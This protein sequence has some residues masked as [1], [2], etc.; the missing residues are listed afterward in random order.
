MRKLFAPNLITRLGI[1]V[2]LASVLPLLLVGVITY[3]VSRSVIEREV[4]SYSQALVNQQAD[5]LDLILHQ[6]AALLANVSGVDAIRDALQTEYD[7][8][9]YFT[10]LST[11]TQIGNILN[12]FINLQG[13]GLVSIDIFGVNGAHYHVGDTLDISNI[14]TE[15]LADLWR[16]SAAAENSVL[17]AGVEQN[18]NSSST[19]TPVITVVRQLRTTDA[20]TLSEEPLALVVV[21]Y[22][23]DALHGYFSQVNLGEGAYMIVLDS[24]NRLVYHPNRTL[25]GMTISAA[26]AEHL[27]RRPAD[28]LVVDG[29]P[30]LITHV[31]S[32]V[33]GWRL[34]SFIPTATLAAH[35]NTIG[36]MTFFAVLAALGL[37]SIVTWQ[38]SSTVV[39]PLKKITDAFRHANAGKLDE[40]IDISADR[41]DEIGD[42]VHSFNVF[43]VNLRVR[44]A[45]VQELHR[46]KEAA[47]AANTA[48]SEFLANISHEIRTPMNGIIGMT[49]LLLTTPINDEQRDYLNTLSISA[50]S[51][52]TLINDI[53]DVAK[54]EAGKLALTMA[55]FNLRQLI[56]DVLGLLAPRAFGKGIELL[57]WVEMETPESCVGDLA[58]L[59]QVLLNLLGNAI[60]FTEHG[61]VSLSVRPHGA[62]SDPFTL[63]FAVQDTGIG[64]PAD[65]QAS[66]FEPFTQADGSTTRR[67]GGTGL[68]LTISRNLVELMGGELWVESRDSEGST[69][70]F[71]VKLAAPDPEEASLPVHKHWPQL[72]GLTAL[73]Y[74]EQPLLRENLQRIVAT[75]GLKA[76]T[77]ASLDEARAHLTA[78]Q[79]GRAV[80]FMLFDVPVGE[81]AVLE[82]TPAALRGLLPPPCVSVPLLSPNDYGTAVN[83][84]RRA[85]YPEILVK[86]TNCARLAAALEACLQRG[87]DGEEPVANAAIPATVTFKAPERAAPTA[88]SAPLSRLNILLAE[89]NAV[90]QK[91]ALALLHRRG[92]T[93]TVVDNGRAALETAAQNTFDLVLMDVQMPEM[94]GLD[95][96][97]ALREREIGT[98]RHLPVI[99]MTA[100][101]MKGDEERCLEAGMDDYIAKPVQAQMLYAVIDRVVARFYSAPA[102]DG[103]EHSVAAHGLDAPV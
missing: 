13:S 80:H 58:R 84:T 7:P 27:E 98:G 61:G 83:L 35:A 75:V 23:I 43:L 69:F 41:T 40:N 20:A 30:M 74:V 97:R 33:S 14:N 86:P 22:D 54:I 36:A 55:P 95:A 62:G 29:E 60:K 3:N 93:V 81:L 17:W 21:N 85:G 42:L 103:V 5:Y 89:D 92:H 88:P 77:A 38:I 10:R 79:D 71:T 25:I 9:D 101:A 99:A 1:F 28:T 78:A 94:G 46:A 90:N 53:L 24:L 18:V 82:T 64:I 57:G 4:N 51:L 72:E 12:P 65:K 26:F 76:L 15:T 47:E 96:T 91:L 70:Y 50:D 68:G 39:A 48:K 16:R 32:P 100:H 11:N 102:A 6:L 67:F 45:T 8:D 34:F 19:Y 56:D 2:L 49:D 52:L 37:V 66:I 31:D 63:Q 87:G 44:Q 59:R 73:I